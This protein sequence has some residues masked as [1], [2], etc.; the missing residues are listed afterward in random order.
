VEVIGQTFCIAAGHMKQE[1]KMPWTDKDLA[2]K[3]KDPLQ[4]HVIAEHPATRN[5]MP[6]EQAPM[7]ALLNSQPKIT[8]DLGWCRAQ[9]PPTKAQIEQNYEDGAEAGRGRVAANAAFGTR[10]LLRPAGFC[11]GFNC[12]PPYPA[13]TGILFSACGLPRRF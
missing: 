1:D 6:I 12:G 4:Q 5:G 2:L 13:V 8:C 3:M 7:A 9:I 10:R 11:E